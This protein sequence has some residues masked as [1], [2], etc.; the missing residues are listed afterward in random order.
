MRHLESQLH[1]P[2][3]LALY[4]Q[5]WL[6]D[7]SPKGMLAFAHGGGEHSGRYHY[8]GEALANAGYALHMA[9]LRGH[10]K[11][12]GKRGHI[13]AWEEYHHDLAAIMESA[14][15]LA[16][17]A[18]QFFGGASLGGLVAVSF[19]RLNPAGAAGLV[20]TGPFFQ[21]AWQPTA[22]KLALANALSRMLP[23]LMMDNDFDP[24][25][26]TRC[27]DT[28]AAYH[29]D[30]LV[31]NQVSVRAATEILAA[32]PD[33]LA[34]AAEIRLP[35]LVLQGSEDK[36]SD[37]S[38]TRA[39]VEA[40]SSADKTLH[41]YDGLYHEVCNEPEKDRVIADLIAWLDAHA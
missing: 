14:A 12:P 28:L 1:T 11:S 17:G 34:H 22:W 13:L 19:A 31:H 15:Q 27:P 20:L 18:P 36:L 24:A 38:A 21:T 33:T 37:L 3:G 29:A 10:G 25:T 30:P 2:D 5:T 39:F 40:A 32:Q 4:A 26:V 16:P 8:L 7:G 6:P 23:G 9:D 35:L 41:I